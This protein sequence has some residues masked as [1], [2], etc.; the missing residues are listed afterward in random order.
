MRWLLYRVTTIQS[1][2]CTCIWLYLNFVLP[3]LLVGM[4]MDSQEIDKELQ[5]L[6]E[7]MKMANQKEEHL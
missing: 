2:H 1:F 3:G 5:E 6:V 4:D 7:G